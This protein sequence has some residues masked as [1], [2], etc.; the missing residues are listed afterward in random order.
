MN[1]ERMICLPYLVFHTF[2]V[3]VGFRFS[4][5]KVTQRG[6]TSMDDMMMDYEYEFRTTEMKQWWP[7]KASFE[8]EQLVILSRLFLL[9]KRW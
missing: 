2:D 4:I 7:S 5:K 6:G 9:K 1:L 3:E 8:I